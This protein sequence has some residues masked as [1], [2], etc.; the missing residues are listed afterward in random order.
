MDIY[1]FI[2]ILGAAF[3]LFGL[4]RTSIGRWQHKSLWYEID[5]ALGATLLIIYLIHTRAYIGIVIN[6][7]YAFVAFKGLSSYAE[8]RFQ[9]KKSR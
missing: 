4:Y 3:V 8:R 6:A 7:A 9:K 5:N 2:G 1:N